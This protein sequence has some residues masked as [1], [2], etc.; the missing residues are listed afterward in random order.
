MIWWEVLLK[1]SSHLWVL[2][3]VLCFPRLV[4]VDWQNTLELLNS[5]FTSLPPIWSASPQ[6]IHQVFLL[7][8]YQHLRCVAGS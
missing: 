3:M 8:I 2:D 6:G 7:Q 4:C 1:Q 5:S